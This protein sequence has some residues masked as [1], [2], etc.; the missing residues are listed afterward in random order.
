[1]KTLLFITHVS[2]DG[3]FTDEFVAYSRKRDAIRGLKR[4]AKRLGITD[5]TLYTPEGPEKINA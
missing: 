4:M 3:T 5:V 1:M 2:L